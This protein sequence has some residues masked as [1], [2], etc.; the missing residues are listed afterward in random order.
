MTAEQREQYLAGQHVAVLAV[1]RET[2]PPLAVPVWYAYEPVATS[3]CRWT[4]RR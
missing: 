4:T 3:S 2:G 1:A